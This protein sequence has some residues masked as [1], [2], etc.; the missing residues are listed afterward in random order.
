MEK[1]CSRT[2]G[3][4]DLCKEK[5]HQAKHVH[6]EGWLNA[7]ADRC[8]FL[9][10][11]SSSCEITGKVYCICKACDL[12]IRRGTK[13][14]M[15]GILPMDYCPRWQK[16]KH[17]KT[18][19]C[20]PHC[21]AEVRVTNHTFSLQTVCKCLGIAVIPI[22][23]SSLPLCQSHYSCVYRLCNQEKICSMICKVCGAKQKH[24]YRAQRFLPCPEPEKV[25]VFLKE[26][27]DSECFLSDGDLVCH[28]CYRYCKHI[29]QTEGC[30]L[31][32]DDIIKEL[33]EKERYLEHSVS[34]LTS[35][36]RDSHIELALKKTALYMCKLILNDHAVLFPAVYAKLR[37]FLPSME[38]SVSKARLLTYIGN[39]FGS[40]M[41]STCCHKRVGRIFF[42][43]KSDPYILLSH[44]LGSNTGVNQGDQHSQ[45]ENRYQGVNAYNDHL[46]TQ[47]H[48]LV[49]HL[50]SEANTD[51]SLSTAL[52]VEKFLKHV[53]CVAPDVWEHICLL[54]RSVNEWKGRKSAVKTVFL[55]ASSTSAEHSSLVLFYSVPMLN[56]ATHFMCN[57]R[58]QSSPVVALRS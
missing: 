27:L 57:W 23:D 14:K 44:A 17:K 3:D 39:E 55:S 22:D 54:T 4:C 5:L 33:Q 19:C 16:H 25:G 47:V 6:T 29:L 8:E 30:M 36:S 52:D 18:Q 11:Y 15:K 35:D 58:M 21:S 20:V 41:S 49:S 45:G 56:V 50:I 7:H 9:E 37:K 42:R 43:S 40:L 2:S 31:S 28:S 34:E 13:M 24:D 46:N 32:S 1:Q 10:E 26:T 48:L 53:Q 38:D 12:C 51:A